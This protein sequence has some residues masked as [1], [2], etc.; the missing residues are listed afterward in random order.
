VKNHKTAINLTTTE[1]NAKYAEIWNP[2]NFSHILFIIDHLAA[3]SIKKKQSF[4]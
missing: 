3:T 2:W 4:Y 1:A